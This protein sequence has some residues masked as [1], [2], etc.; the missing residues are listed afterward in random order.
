MNKPLDILINNLRVQFRATRCTQVEIAEKA[1]VSQV[2][3]SQILS[4]KN[5]NPR[6]E[7]L[8]NLAAALGTTVSALFQDPDENIAIT[9]QQAWLTIR[10]FLDNFFFIYKK[11]PKE[12]QW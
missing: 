5:R 9:P 6:L 8:G 4:G 12:F 1:G 10:P 2:Y 3:I 11:G 7:H